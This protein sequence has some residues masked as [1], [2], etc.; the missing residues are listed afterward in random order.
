MAGFFNT[1]A[2]L[3]GRYRKFLVA[4]AAGAAV[5]INETAGGGSVRW[6]DVLFAVLGALGVAIVPNASTPTPP[7]PAKV[8]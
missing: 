7:P 1:V 2:T 5:V 4:G 6:I 8:A 3:A